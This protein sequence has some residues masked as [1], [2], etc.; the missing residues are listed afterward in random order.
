MHMDFDFSY[1]LREAEQR[2]LDF[3]HRELTPNLTDWYREG[4]VPRSFHKAMGSEGWFGF[5]FKA[6]RLSR[7]S[8]LREAVL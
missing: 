6:G 8:A 2:F 7:G 3:L 1:D 5:E 4:N